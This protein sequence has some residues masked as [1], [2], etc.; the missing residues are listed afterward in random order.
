M[1]IAFHGNMTPMFHH[2]SLLNYHVLQGFLVQH[3][4]HHP[5]S[6]H[7]S[8]LFCWLSMVKLHCS[9]SNVQDLTWDTP[10]IKRTLWDSLW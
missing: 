4:Q 5:R 2:V 9:C 7:C 10:Y 3:E 1:T 8:Q 6:P